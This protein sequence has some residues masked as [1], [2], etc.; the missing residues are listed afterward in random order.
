MNLQSYDITA[1]DTAWRLLRKLR[2]TS[3]G[4]RADF[5]RSL[6]DRQRRQIDVVE[7]ILRGLLEEVSVDIL[8]KRQGELV[9][10]GIKEA[11]E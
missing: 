8:V 11:S 2:Q 9:G 10:N 7:G 3:P 5:A 1:I 6:T 4:K